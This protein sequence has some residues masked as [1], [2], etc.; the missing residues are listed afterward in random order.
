MVLG[1]YCG[2]AFPLDERWDGGE[3][4]TVLEENLLKRSIF[5]DKHRRHFCC[6]C[7]RRWFYKIF[8]LRELH[9][10]DFKSS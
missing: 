8:T 5:R 4:E 3:Y 9:L 6:Y 2:H 1:F 10:Y 7:N